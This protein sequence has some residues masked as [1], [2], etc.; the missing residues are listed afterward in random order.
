MTTRTVDQKTRF[1]TVLIF[2]VLFVAIFLIRS[3]YSTAPELGGDAARKWEVSRLLAETGDFRL[4][5]S[6]RHHS[7]RWG[8][9]LLLAA[10]IKING[11]TVTSYLLVPLLMYAGIF[12]MMMSFGRKVLTPASLFAL[13]VFLFYEPMFFRAST[14]PQPF[15]FGVFFISAALW[16]MTKYL[17]K[18]KFKYLLASAIFAFLAYGAKESYLFFFPGLFLLLLVKTDVRRCLYYAGLLGIF[19]LI[20]TLVFNAVSD[21]LMFGRIEYLKS[22]HHLISMNKKAVFG[23]YPILHFLTQ[24]WIETTVFNQVITTVFSLY[25]GYLL[26][27]R[28]LLS[29]DSATL[30]IFLL[31]ASYIA[32]LTFVPLKIDPLL[33][34]Q[35]LSGK[36]LT[37]IMPFTVFCCIYA[38]DQAVRK[39]DGANSRRWTI[40]VLAITTGFLIYALVK[41]SPFKYSFHATYPVKDAFLWKQRGHIDNLNRSLDDGLGICV[42]RWRMRKTILYWLDHYMKLGKPGRQIM[43]SNEN[44]NK[45]LHL[46]KYELAALQGYIPPRE[47]MKILAMPMCANKKDP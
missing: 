10:M 42:K 27:S 22:G 28:K 39:F 44:K 24:R 37:T 6:D 26:F 38:L 11:F 5:I 33:S 18:D 12:L 29:L 40:G 47:L 15:V 17:E 7:A 30:G 13:G 2:A 23:G 21:G 16:F 14:N 4:L 25:L 19:L 1:R 34:I 9:N 8:I 35:P 3:W 32:I 36:Y 20:E 41:E 31:T 45:I 46:D 43:K